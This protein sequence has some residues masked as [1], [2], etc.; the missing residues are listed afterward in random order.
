M[1][2][3]ACF[4]LLHDALREI[5][6]LADVG[7]ALSQAGQTGSSVVFQDQAHLGQTALED[8]CVACSPDIS[9]PRVTLAGEA[10]RHLIEHASSRETAVADLASQLCACYEEL[11]V[12]YELL[13][14]MASKVTEQEIGGA[15]VA[16]VA[17]TLNCRRVSLLV[18]DEQQENLRVLA[19]VG[20]PEEA[21]NAVIPVKT[22]VAGKVLEEADPLL[23]EDICSRPDLAELSR[24][25]YETGVFAVIRVPL[26]T[27]GHPVGVLAVTERNDSGDFTSHDCK[28]LEGLSAMGAASL[29]H[30]RLQRMVQEQMMS[31]IRALALAVDAKDH[32]THAHS[33]RVSRFCVAAARRMG[34]TETG[35]LREIE[36]AG[37]LHDVGKI[38]IPDAILSKPGKLTPEEHR[39]LIQTHVHVGAQ[40]V[41]HVKGL[42]NVAAAILHHHERYDGLGG[43]D[44]LRGDSIPLMSRLVA[45]ADTFDAMTSDRP[46]RKALSLQVALDELARCS[47]TQFD[48]SVVAAFVAALRESPSICDPS[49]STP[50]VA[51]VPAM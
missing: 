29:M 50:P 48:P 31:T 23:V 44:G 36:L 9:S 22:S 51:A 46:Y 20:L 18:L 41:A 25:S 40:I 28:L 2:D 35:L 5:A 24:G 14:S 30:C 6:S 39:H 37:I 47:G 4:G 34:I 21:R 15:L 19:S 38:A 7:L 17:E 43:P 32:Y 12:T 8:D 33:D 42:E 11:N 13:Q 3:S 16:R 45:V 49:M 27:Q 26:R 1:A 10:I